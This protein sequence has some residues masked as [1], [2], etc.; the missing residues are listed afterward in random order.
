MGDFLEAS[1]GD[2]EALKEGGSA[3]AQQKKHRHLAPDS[4]GNL[5]L[6]AGCSSAFTRH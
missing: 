2:V 1:G 3:Q 4:L 5:L 6:M